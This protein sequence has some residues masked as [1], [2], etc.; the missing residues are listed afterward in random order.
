MRRPQQKRHKPPSGWGSANSSRKTR[1]RPRRSPFSR[2]PNWYSKFPA[3][4]I[5]QLMS[6]NSRGPC[7]N[8]TEEEAHDISDFHLARERSGGR[9][10][11]CQCRGSWTL[12]VEGCSAPKENEYLL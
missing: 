10:I 9:V 11:C 1:R 5:A 12:A 6:G 7:I 8:E 2:V 3:C 4:T